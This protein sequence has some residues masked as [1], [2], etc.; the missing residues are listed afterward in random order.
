MPDSVTLNAS[1][2]DL[3]DLARIAR[4]AANLAAEDGNRDEMVRLR[5]KSRD[6]RADAHAID[7]GHGCPAWAAADHSRGTN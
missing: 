3:L 2:H 7:P 6:L 4:L 1:V 5:Q